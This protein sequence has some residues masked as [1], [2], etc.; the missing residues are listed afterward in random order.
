MV[1]LLGTHEYEWC[2]PLFNYLFKK[3]WG[4]EQIIYIADYLINPLPA[5]IEFMQVPAYSEGEWNWAQWFSNGFASICQYFE[6]ELLIV[7]LLDHWLN[8]P[9]KIDLVNQLLE[10][11]KT[12]SNILRG[13]LT[14]GTCLDGYGKEYA[15]YKDLDIVYVPAHNLHCSFGGGVTFCPS[16]FNP[17]N[18]L[19]VLGNHWSMHQTEKLGT[20]RMSEI[21]ELKSIGTKQTILYRTHALSHQT[22]KQISLEGLNENDKEVIKEMIPD[23]WHVK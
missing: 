5:N 13:N 23:G 12:H 18:T 17:K 21:S 1:I 2:I 15:T 6:N 14:A 7:F 19:R 3:Y 22:P 10:Y 8:A 9:V 16:I 20:E 11:M 4:N